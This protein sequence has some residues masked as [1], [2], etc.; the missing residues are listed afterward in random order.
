MSTEE[1]DTTIQTAHNVAGRDVN[2]KEGG[3]RFEGKMTGGTVVGRDQ[4][5]TYG[6]TTEEVAVLVAELKR[7]N[8]P[9]VWNGRI[10][11]IGLSAFQES[12]AQFFF[13]RESLMDKRYRQQGV[14]NR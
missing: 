13:G 8:Q 10:P 9:I 5:V 3:V 7:V 2:V 14:E 4:Y 11:Y 12:D 1:A 6:L